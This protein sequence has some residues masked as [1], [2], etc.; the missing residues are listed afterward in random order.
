MAK[1]EEAVHKPKAK[2]Y[3]LAK[4]LECLP[5]VRK[6]FRKGCPLVREPRDSLGETPL[7]TTRALE[8]NC[9]ILMTIIEFMTSRKVSVKTLEP[10][11]AVSKAYIDHAFSFSTVSHIVDE[12]LRKP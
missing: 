4:L 6:R 12:S 3:R 11:V 5:L 1:S 10:Q 8:L 2:D 7:Q 9:S